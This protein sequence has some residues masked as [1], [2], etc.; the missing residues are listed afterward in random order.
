VASLIIAIDGPAA[1]GKSTTAKQVA[2]RLGYTYIDSGAMYRAAALRALRL[3]ISMDDHAALARVAR[4]ASIELAER[5]RGPVVLDGEDVSTAIRASEV[6][7]ASSIMSSVPGVRR[8][9]VARQRE[10]GRSADCVMEGRDIGTVVFPEAELKV[11]LTAS[12]AER[13]RRRYEQSATQGFGELTEDPRSRDMK[14]RTFSDE[15]AARDKRDTTRD[16]SPLR[17]AADAVELDTT[18]LTIDE[19]IQKV[20]ELAVER[21]AVDRGRDDTRRQ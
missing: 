18:A 5:G 2:D 4:E 10:I 8:A 19:Q 3:G 17:R 6:T 15:I 21:G 14:L 13:A 11:F 20:V 7:A 16:D 9:L 1:S 12:L